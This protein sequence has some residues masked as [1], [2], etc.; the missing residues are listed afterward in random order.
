MKAIILAGG[1][2]TRLYPMTTVFS[3]Q[4]QPIYDKPMIYYPLST[5]MLLGIRDF[6]LISTPEDTPHFA[7]LLGDGT[8]WGIQIEYRVQQHPGGL[9]QAFLVAEDWIAGDACG[10]ILGDN[11]FYGKMNLFASALENFTQGAVI[12]GYPVSDPSSY[13]V[14]RFSSDGAPVDI[15]EKPENPP[16][17]IAVPGLYFYDAQVVS[18]CKQLRPSPRGELEITDLNRSYLQMGQLRVGMLGRGVTWLDTGTPDSLLEAAEFVRIMEH[19]QGL[20][21]G[22]PEEAALRMG[23]IRTKEA[24]DLCHSLPNGSYRSYLQRVL[25]EHETGRWD[26]S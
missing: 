2:G 6:C 1:K 15:E 20:K 25:T 22:C 12:Y 11:L 16:S 24:I 10:L 26:A 23:F 8:N 3:K 13:G 19:R 14:L 5:L 9:A 18:L 7:R 21:I 17:N 4:L